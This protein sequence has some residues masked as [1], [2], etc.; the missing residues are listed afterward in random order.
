MFINAK[1]EDSILKNKFCEIKNLSE[2]YLLL[3]KSAGN[4]IADIV[5]LQNKKQSAE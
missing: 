4:N 1:I 3:E 2:L 5:L